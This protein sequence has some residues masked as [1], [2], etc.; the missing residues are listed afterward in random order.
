MEAMLINEDSKTRND[1]K[2]YRIERK[3]AEIH[4]KISALEDEG[5]DYHIKRIM[6]AAL[7]DCKDDLIKKLRKLN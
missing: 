5:C 6:L 7:Y 3:I 4:K 1:F 2:E